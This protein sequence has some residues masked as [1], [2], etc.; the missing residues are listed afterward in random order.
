MAYK[1]ALV[2]DDFRQTLPVIPRL[3]AADEI[4]ACLKSTNLWRYVKKLQL[5]ANIRVAL[6]NDPSAQDFS[7]QLLTIISNGRVPVYESSRLISFPP[8]FCEILSSKDELINNVFP[9]IIA[10]HKNNKWLSEQAI[11][12]AKMWMA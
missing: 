11:L 7:K 6:L 4:N 5:E 8:N 9:N 10:N 2:S 1:R 3:T 12:A